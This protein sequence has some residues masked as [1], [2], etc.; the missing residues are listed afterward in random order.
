MRLRGDRSKSG[1]TLLELLLAVTL[2]TVLTGAIYTALKV[3]QGSVAQGERKSER[4]TNARA[5]LDV[6]SREI[7]C[8]VVSTVGSNEY[9]LVGTNS[10]TED[11]IDLVSTAIIE[12]SGLYDLYEVGYRLDTT[13]DRIRRRWNTSVDG[14]FDDSNIDDLAERATGL[15]IRYYKASPAGWQ[16][17]WNSVTDDPGLL[18][19]AV[20]ISL[21]VQDELAAEDAQT[22]TTVVYMGNQR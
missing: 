3:G 9:K 10:G 5:A 14:T 17:T 20:E 11:V 19:A 2:T 22:F 12:A 13:N 8:A 16:D 6:M 1:L 15:N 4:Y 7:Q 18:P 21:T